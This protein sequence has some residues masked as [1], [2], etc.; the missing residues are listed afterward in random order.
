MYARNF[1]LLYV[2]ALTKRKLPEETGALY[3]RLF[4]FIVFELTANVARF[5]LQNVMW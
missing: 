5:W 4:Q 2:L 3:R 1:N